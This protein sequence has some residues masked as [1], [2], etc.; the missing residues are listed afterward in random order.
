MIKVLNFWY[1]KIVLRFF[2]DKQKIIYK[3]LERSTLKLEKKS[4]LMFNE[5]YYNNN[6]YSKNHEIVQNFLSIG[7]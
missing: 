7:F 6:L 5:T 1:S 2:K 3:N 4:H